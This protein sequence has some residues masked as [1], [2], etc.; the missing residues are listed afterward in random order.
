MG[1][2]L[3]IQIP[4]YNE[5]K[6]LPFVL[7]DLPGRID[8]IDEIYTIVI[9][10]GSEDG[11]F[12]TARR[13]GVDYIE[14]NHRNMGLARSFQKG[15]EACLHLGADIIVNTDGDNQYCGKDILKLVRPVLERK[16]DVIVGCRDI[17]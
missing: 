12:Y 15:L 11:T 1:V 2:K 3:F 4:C 17:D 9:D 6:T 5:E 14:R 16:A 8:G 10:D 7:N 13:L